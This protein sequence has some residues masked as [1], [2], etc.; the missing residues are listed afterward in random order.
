MG[1][2]LAANYSDVVPT[3][4]IG[5]WKV[6]SA[7]R[8]A[9]AMPVSLW[10]FR[11]DHMKHKERT[12]KI[13]KKYLSHVETCLHAQLKLSHPELLQI[14]EVISSG[15]TL[16]F[17]SEP[18]VSVLSREKTITKD[19]AVYISLALALV[20]RD[21]Q[22]QHHLMCGSASPDNIFLKH[23][24]T[25][26]LGL[27]LHSV[28]FNSPSLPL[29]D[30]FI[31]YSP[32]S[33]FHFPPSCVAPELAK[34]KNYLPASEVYMYALCCLYAFTNKITEDSSQIPA[35]LESTP[36]AYQGLL[37]D[38]LVEYPLS[39]PSFEDILSREV[40][41]SLVCGVFQFLEVITTKEPSAVMDFLKGLRS[42]ITVFSVR[43]V[44]LRF[45]PLFLVLMERDANF[46]T[47]VV[48]MLMTAEGKFTDD[49]FIDELMRPLKNVLRHVEVPNVLIAFLDRT[50]ILLR[51]VPP[52]MRPEFVYPVL[53]ASIESTDEGLNDQGL[54]SLPFFM[55]AIDED[56]AGNLIR[57]V[58]KLLERTSK[59]GIAL[60]AINLFGV[61]ICKIG[62]PAVAQI[63]APSIFQVWRRYHWPSLAPPAIDLLYNLNVPPEMAMSHVIVLA[64]DIL[65]YKQLQPI[66]QGRLIAL[67]TRIIAGLQIEHQLTPIVMDQA[68][69]HETPPAAYPD[70]AYVPRAADPELVTEVSESEDEQGEVNDGAESPTISAES[71]AQGSP[72]P[73]QGSLFPPQGSSFPN[74]RSP[75]SN[76]GSPFP[77]QASPFPDQGSLF[78]PQGS[79][80]P[81]R[82]SPVS[83]Q[84][85][86]FPAQASPFPDQGSLFPPQGSPFP[87]QASPVPN[88][89]SP[90]PAQASPFPDQGSLFPPQ[91]SPVFSPAQ[92]LFANA[93]S[94]QV[95]PFTAD[96]GASPPQVT[97]SESSELPRP[98]SG[99]GWTADAPAVPRTSRGRRRDFGRAP[100]QSRRST[101]DIVLPARTAHGAARPAPAPFAMEAQP[102]D[103]SGFQF[104]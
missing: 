42:I 40:F 61:A 2:S 12:K 72:F 6:H 28:P 97:R 48:P 55:S 75:V 3:F 16:G 41:S 7:I 67:I 89:G 18:I 93:S 95:G 66:A 94:G 50:D 10:T 70:T 23:D 96:E 19:E 103:L 13:R 31:A 51:R 46:G 101:P 69:E 59:D 36:G 86:P 62:A 17:A 57:G 73:D 65:S 81:N 20:L 15:K 44:R 1:G 25:L 22:S 58:A 78:P 85:S 43:L 83:N 77:A 54:A 64:A 80:F 56:A 102:R 30:P 90:F 98:Q 45:L 8:K 84:G 88:Q 68:R 99:A 79:P 5:L 32:T 33:C 82:A 91:A 63:A 9:N 71:P 14:F 38:C 24:F 27:L 87:N 34:E 35:S 104:N 29:D 4:E 60:R 49:Q 92:D 76:Q 21:L 26:K 100:L 47:V 53:F 39:R 52:S 74:Q 11:R 37:V